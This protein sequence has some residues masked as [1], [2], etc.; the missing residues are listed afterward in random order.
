MQPANGIEG[1]NP[2]IGFQLIFRSRCR[3]LFAQIHDDSPELQKLIDNSSLGSF[4][5]QYSDEL[6][7]VMTIEFTTVCSDAR[8]LNGS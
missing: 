6:R 5:L 8:E 2:D 4:E 7:I 1:I 3:T